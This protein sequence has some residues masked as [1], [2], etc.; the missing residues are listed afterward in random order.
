MASR[1]V[2]LCWTFQ[3][4]ARERP[5]RKANAATSLRTSNQQVRPEPPNRGGAAHWLP[6]CLTLLI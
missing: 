2:A 5:A 4:E 6:M 3:Q 1:Q